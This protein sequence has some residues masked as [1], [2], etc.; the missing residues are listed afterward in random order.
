MENETLEEKFERFRKAA[1]GNK[2][3]DSK[4]TLALHLAAAMTAGC[5]PCIRNYIGV[6][7][8]E[9]LTLAE[10]DAIQAI[11]MS[12]SACRVKTH[13]AECKTKHDSGE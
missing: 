10:I 5:S 8:R 1:L 12:V 11:V 13:F 4:T 6:A 2:V 9:G 7:E 3:L